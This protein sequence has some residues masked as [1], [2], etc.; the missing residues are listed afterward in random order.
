MQSIILEKFN[1][2]NYNEKNSF[3]EITLRTIK[4]ED[5]IIAIGGRV[6]NFVSISNDYYDA[7]EK[8]HQ[9]LEKLNWKA[10]FY[11]KDIAYKVI[12]K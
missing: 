1:F 10:G 7:R 5:K 9:N 11:R 8:I 4:K 3:L 2:K 6:L 12:N